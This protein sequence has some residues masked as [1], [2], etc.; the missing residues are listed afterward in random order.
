MLEN[1]D[2]VVCQICGKHLK[3][4]VKQHLDMHDITREEYIKQFPEAILVCESVRK[5][6]S[7]GAAK[8][9]SKKSKEELSRIGKLRAKKWWDKYKTS[10]KIQKEY[11]KKLSK[12]VSKGIQK[13][14]KENPERYI[15]TNKLRSKVRKELFNSPETSEK[16]RNICAK[17]AINLW[18]NFSEKEQKEKLLNF[19]NKIWWNNLSIEEKKKHLKNFGGSKETYIINNKE[20]IFRSKFECLVATYLIDKNIEFTY[21]DFVLPLENGS[22]HLVDFFIKNRNLILECKSSY[23]RNKTEEEVLDDVLNKQKE[24]IQLGYNYEIIWYSQKDA[25]IYNQL[26]SIF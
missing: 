17:G 2:Y 4:I 15:V 21:E 7:E 20:Y 5:S 12:N 1:I 6:Y 16:M 8:Y 18:K 25:D 14:K 3:R 22:V 11:G 23:H 26:N 24:A 10:E 19:N 9:L 13:I